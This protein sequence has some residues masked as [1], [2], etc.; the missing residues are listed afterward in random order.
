MARFSDIY[1][2]YSS[3]DGRVHYLAILNPNNL[4]M[5]VYLHVD[6]SSDTAVCSYFTITINY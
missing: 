5:F 1:R 2:L 3:E 4:D 6:E